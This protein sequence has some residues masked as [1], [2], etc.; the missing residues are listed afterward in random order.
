MINHPLFDNPNTL[1]ALPAPGVP[2]VIGYGIP[3]LVFFSVL[4]GFVYYIYLIQN[5]RLSL[6][7]TFIW[8]LFTVIMAIISAYLFII[9]VMNTFG[10]AGY[11]VFTFIA[12]LLGISSNGSSAW[13]SLV[14]LLLLA[15]LYTKAF[16]TTVK[17]SR[18]R[19]DMNV[20]A[21]E[22]AILN[23]KLLHKQNHTYRK[24]NDK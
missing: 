15:F 1:P 19:R 7:E 16:H 13:L 12:R 14:M 22:I 8:L 4:V 23:G 2:T 3:I 24:R 6:R 17:I 21:R 11:N 10:H 18:M 5:N 20:F 9:Q